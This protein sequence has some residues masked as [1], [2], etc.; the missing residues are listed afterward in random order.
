MYVL[1]RSL[2]SIIHNRTRLTLPGD[3][4]GVTVDAAAAVVVARARGQA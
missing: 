3:K 2:N 4:A 1:F